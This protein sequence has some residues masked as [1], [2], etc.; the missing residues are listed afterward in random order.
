MSGGGRCRDPCVARKLSGR[1]R[2]PVGKR[3]EHRRARRVADET[4]E[5][6]EI[7]IALA[8]VVA[9]WRGHSVPRPCFY[10]ATKRFGSTV[11]ED[12]S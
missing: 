9:A 7:T 5:R 3:S 6:R 1:Q 2:P 4:P 12:N 11:A 10:V 8:L